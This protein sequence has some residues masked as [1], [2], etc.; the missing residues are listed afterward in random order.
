MAWLPEQRMPMT[1]DV[2]NELI[3]NCI[4]VFITL[5][6]VTLRVVGRV[7]GPGFGWDDAL[8]VLATVGSM[9]FAVSRTLTYDLVLVAYGR[10]NADLS[11]SL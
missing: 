8:I 1:D 11:R 3:V 2:R 7:S 9:H 4:V 6:V 5:V 10:R